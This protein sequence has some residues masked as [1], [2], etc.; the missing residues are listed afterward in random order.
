[1]K[2]AGLDEQLPLPCAPTALD[3][4][5]RCHAWA[6][7]QGWERNIQTIQF[8]YYNPRGLGICLLGTMSLV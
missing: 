3:I 7:R 4:K 2:Q 5:G 8:H 1:M 6:F